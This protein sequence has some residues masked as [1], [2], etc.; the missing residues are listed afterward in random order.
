MTDKEAIEEMK[1]DILAMKQA[2]D[3]LF[4]HSIHSDQELQRL[5]TS[6]SRLF[7]QVGSL[8]KQALK[9]TG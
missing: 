8:E 2:I 9:Q 3:K 7:T 4:Q 5:N 1:R 6:V